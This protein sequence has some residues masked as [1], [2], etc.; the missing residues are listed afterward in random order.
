MKKKLSLLFVVFAAI[1]AFAVQAARRAAASDG[2]VIFSAD[3]TATAAVGFQPGTTEVTSSQATLVGGK[4]YAISQQAEAKNLIAKQ[5]SYFMFCMTNNNTFFKVELDKALKAGDV[6]SAKTYSRT[7]TNLGLFLSTSESRPGTCDTKLSIDAVSAA[8]YEPFSDYTVAEGDGLEGATTFY[9]YRETGKS[10][11][12]GEFKITRAADDTAADTELPLVLTFPDNNDTSVSAYTRE[13]TATVEGNVWTLYGFNNNNNGWAFVRCGQ[14][15][16]AQTATITSPVVNAA[17]ANVVITVNKAT[18]VTSAKLA[19]LLGETVLAEQDITADFVAGD[20][21]VPVSGTAGCSYKLTVESA[22][23]ANGSTE[24]AKVAIYGEGQY[25]VKHIAN[26]ADA[27]YT[28]AEAIELIEAGEALAEQVYVKGIVSQVDKFNETYSSINYWISDDGTTANQ[29]E[30]YSGKGI[31][32]ADFAS[33]DDVQV[34]ATVIVTGTLTKYN[35]IYEFT[36]SNQLVSYEAPAAAT[37]AWDFTKGADYKNAI[38]ISDNLWTDPSAAKGRGFYVPVLNNEEF[39]ATADTKLGLT[40]GLFFTAASKNILIGFTNNFFMQF[41]G[42]VTVT[43][44]DC[45]AGDTIAVEYCTST[46]GKDATITSASVEEGVSTLNTGKTAF[47]MVV[48]KAGDVALSCN[49]YSR[50]YTLA[51]KPYDESKGA[52]TAPVTISPASGDIAAALAAATNG[53]DNVGDITINLTEGAQYTVSAPIETGTNLV[54]NGNG[55]TI[56]ASANEG[57]V[58]TTPAGDLAEWQEGDLIV[59][60]VTIKGVKKGVFVSNRKNFLFNDF[61]IENSVI[62][63]ASTSGLEFD[64]RKGSVAKNFT[65]NNSTIYAP[66]ATTNSLYTSQSAQRGTEAPGVTVQTFAITNSTLYNLAKGKNFFTHRQSNQTWLA[67]T[68]TNSIFA[69]VGKSGQVVKGINQGQSGKNPTWNI[70]GNTFFFDDADVSAAEDTGDTEEPVKNSLITNPKFANVEAGDF[71]I[72]AGTEQALKQTGDPRWRVEFVEADAADKDFANIVVTPAAGTDIA[73]AIA[74]KEKVVNPL[75]ITVN[76]EAANYSISEALKG[77]NDI[78][79]NGHGATVDASAVSGAFVS[80]AQAPDFGAAAPRRAT[81]KDEWADLKHTVT[82]KNLTVNGLAAPVFKNDATGNVRLDINVDNVVAEIAANVIVFDVHGTAAFVENLNINNSTFYAPTATTQS[83]FSAQSAKNAGDV[84]DDAK[85]GTALQTFKFTNSTFYNL[86][87]GKNFFTLRQSGQVFLAFNLQK[88]IF[89]NCG[90]TGQTLKGF[91]QGQASANPQWSVDLNTFMAGGK[92]QAEADQTGDAEEPATNN[93]PTDPQFADAANGDFHIGAGTAQAKEQTGDP[94][95]LVAYDENLRPAQDIELVANDIDDDINA[96]IAA[97]QSEY[98][99]GINDLTINLAA[100]K[101]YTIDA[102]IEAAGNIVI[103]GNKATIDASA[104]TGA[105]IQLSATP[106]EVI[107][108]GNSYYQ[109][110]AE[111]LVKDVTVTGVNSAILYDNG[112]QYSLRAATIDNS[113]IQLTTVS[114]VPAIRFNTGGIKDF[115]VK[116]STIYQAG[117]SNINYFIQY[118][119]GARNDRLGY[120]DGKTTMTYE[121]NTFYK[122]GTSNWG[123][124]SGISNNSDYVVKSNLWFDCG[125]GQTARRILGNGRLGSN[126][127]AQ[128]DNNSYWYNDADESASGYD[129]SETIV[130]G[131]P[132]FRKLSYVPGDFTL[133]VCRQ[134]GKKVGDP[135]WY[136]VPVTTYLLQ[137]ALNKA[138][139]LLDAAQP[140]WQST[141]AANANIAALAEAY[142]ENTPYLASDSQEEIDE[143]TARVEAAIAAFGN[144]TTGIAGVNADA[145]NDVWYTTNGQ[146]INKPTTKG[147]YIHNGKK[148]VVK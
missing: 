2:E 126:A 47:E 127:T 75:N 36:Q 86:A 67:Y 20:V 18:N 55:A 81:L 14:R 148:V 130:T 94:R 32:G 16:N 99:K 88:N 72:G 87:T 54:I 5:S 117:E 8:A 142:N 62:E 135:R 136:N 109:L 116:K 133:G 124:Y 91:N 19:T 10:T 40:E 147:I 28:V 26:T 73:T 123:N 33:V 131:K 56:D 66:E 79:I 11:Y 138:A 41:T 89:D 121:N 24:I 90:K 140:D 108:N 59:K 98:F 96:A 80:F 52:Y 118:N 38:T 70:D 74:E 43:V 68:I 105:F 23:G 145:D 49:A 101:E 50:F 22:A 61:T 42:G 111:I 7:D 34:G 63:I 122:V 58:I 57:A 120:A 106:D 27:P 17:V 64:F 48:K 83:F 104:N 15:N 21:N 97:K 9:I 4:M 71:T 76:L 115:T 144:G 60:D 129:T 113:V 29:L 25:V 37:R 77:S 31:E 103:N 82:I 141:D 45:A 102:P 134:I 110:D 65:I 95:W 112:K 92:N 39:K 30:C 128:W 125:N 78:I 107:K 93:L 35:T 6:I 85:D 139:E 146:R 13:W 51:V 114:P 100:D 69:N 44:P 132:L 84:Y 46:K 12:F 137:N 53:I 143:A 119:N 1:A 3:V